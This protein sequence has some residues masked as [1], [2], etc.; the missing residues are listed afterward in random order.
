MEN[1]H[2]NVCVH[3]EREFDYHKVS[4]FLQDKIWFSSDFELAL[5]KK[6]SRIC[7]N[8]CVCVCVLY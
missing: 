5:P 1:P 6:H 2:E 3:S 4:D 7:T 8:V